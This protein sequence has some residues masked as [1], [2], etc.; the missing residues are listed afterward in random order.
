MGCPCGREIRD[1]NPPYC[2]GC[3][4]SPDKCDCRPLPPDATCSARGYRCTGY[5]EMSLGAL[6]EVC[7]PCGGQLKVVLAAQEE[8]RREGRRLTQEEI[9]GIVDAHDLGVE[10]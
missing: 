2:D 5:A 4:L 1:G 8:A 3:R 6:G 10:R 7:L 9:Q